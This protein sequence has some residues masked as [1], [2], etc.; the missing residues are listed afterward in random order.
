MGRIGSPNAYAYIRRRS[1][2][3]N[4]LKSRHCNCELVLVLR[5]AGAS[6]GVVH[7][8]LE[9]DPRPEAASD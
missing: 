4:L 8:E 3:D 6:S 7:A 5:S 1:S 9:V 2:A